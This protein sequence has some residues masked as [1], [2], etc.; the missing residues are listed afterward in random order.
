[1]ANPS[2]AAFDQIF[3]SQE[4]SNNV[5]VALANFEDGKSADQQLAALWQGLGTRQS[6]ALLKLSIENKLNSTD[7]TLLL[8]EHLPVDC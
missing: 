4:Q 7:G 5:W 6:P 8:P 1:M 3:P 2:Q